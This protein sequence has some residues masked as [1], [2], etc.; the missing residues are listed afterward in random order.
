M[1]DSAQDKTVIQSGR[2]RRLGLRD[3]LFCI[4]SGLAFLPPLF[5]ELNLKPTVKIFDQTRLEADG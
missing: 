5:F 2:N 4:G 1:I 3:T